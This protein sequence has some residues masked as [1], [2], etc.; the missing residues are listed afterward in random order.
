MMNDGGH[1]HHSSLI[2]HHSSVTRSIGVIGGGI[3]GLATAREL[4][5][6]H[7]DLSVTLLEKEAALA[8]H[9]TGH[10]SGVIHSG[11]YY[12]PGSAKARTCTRGG[13]LLRRFCDESAI[14]YEECGKVIV[15]RTE[16]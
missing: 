13:A 12:K 15:A 7:P 5:R 11:V 8:S 1:R 3:V 14:P 16:E 10:N 2:I 6:R 4:L 9:Q